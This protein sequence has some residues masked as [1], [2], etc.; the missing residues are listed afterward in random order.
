MTYETTTIYIPVSDSLGWLNRYSDILSQEAVGWLEENVGK[1]APTY[2][3]FIANLDNDQF[4]WCFNGKAHDPT[5]HYLHL[6]YALTFKNANDAL[7]FKLS[8]DR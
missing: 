2:M 6:T 4:G 7:M 8:W 5:T 3:E 1:Q